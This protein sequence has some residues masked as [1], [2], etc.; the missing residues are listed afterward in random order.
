MSILPQLGH[1]AVLGSMLVVATLA[2]RPSLNVSVPPPIDCGPR[3][4]IPIDGW[5]GQTGNNLVQ[6]THAVTLAKTTRTPRLKVPPEEPEDHIGPVHQVFNLPEEI[7]LDVE[8]GDSWWERTFFCTCTAIPAN[9]RSPCSARDPAD[10]FEAGNEA[11]RLVMSEV[12]LPLI[13]PEF[14]EC[15]DVHEKTLTIHGRYGDVGAG[16][17]HDIG[18]YIQEQLYPCAFY[19]L[20]IDTYGFTRVMFL[21]QPGDDPGHPCIGNLRKRPDIKFETDT[22]LEGAVCNFVKAT[23]LV[24]PMS[25]FSMTFIFA[26][27][28]VQRIFTGALGTQH[29]VLQSFARRECLDESPEVFE[30]DIEDLAKV[31]TKADKVRY[32]TNPH[33]KMTPSTR[34]CLF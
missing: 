2:L 5:Y 17:M 20:L 30:Y 19:H 16:R 32:M 21:T 34:R 24:A 31:H 11:K 1:L 26:N 4:I 23:N 3:S 6:L 33:L 13:R 18:K 7:Q 9:F 22:S 12:M 25:T 27:T 29:G 14:L 28:Q 10:E 8:E 15:E